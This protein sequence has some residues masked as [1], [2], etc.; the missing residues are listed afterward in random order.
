MKVVA[1][2]VTYGNRQHLVRQVIDRLLEMP[3]SRIYLIDNDSTTKYESTEK[4]AVI[5]ISENY[6]SAGGYK[7]GLH[8]VN[9]TNADLIWLLDDDNVPD[10]DALDILL[11]YYESFTVKGF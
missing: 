1:I 8:W 3:I 7:T 6:G 5:R 4:V 10:K 9:R 2:V 11:S